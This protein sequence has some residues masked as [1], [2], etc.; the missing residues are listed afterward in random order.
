MSRRA[1]MCPCLNNV[2]SKSDAWMTLVA[3][4]CLDYCLMAEERLHTAGKK[5]FKIGQCDKRDQ[6]HQI[7]GLNAQTFCI[8]D[9]F[10]SFDSAL[11]SV[12][13]AY[14]PILATLIVHLFW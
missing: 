9:N 10:V 8:F 11:Q 13:R 3:E 12:Q 7:I 4:I 14:V 6:N 5:T 1:R 2:T